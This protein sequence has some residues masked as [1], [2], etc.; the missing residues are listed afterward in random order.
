MQPYFFP[1]IGYF[2]LMNY[3]DVWVVFDDIQFIDKGWI[4]RNRIL[5]PD[6]GKEWQFITIPLKGR[7]Q[8]SNITQID[9]NDDE[10]WREKIRGQLGHYKKKVPFYF[11]TMDFVNSC[12][13]IKESNLSNY[14]SSVLI[15]TSKYLGINTN[16]TIQSQMK[17]DLGEIE[18]SGQWALKIS[19]SIGAKEYINPESG[20]SLFNK[21]E[22]ESLGI[23][24][25]FFKPEIEVYSQK[26]EKFI[27]G[28]SIIDVLMWNG[29]EVTKQMISR[30]YV[31]T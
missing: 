7:K 26:R 9:V 29:V 8:F 1:Y 6:V 18:H 3:A 4:N 22:F 25:S 2:Q 21:K 12:L 10:K 13:N 11:E 23:E 28:L 5:H 31:I 15:E 14:V 17:L 27:P 30:N 16:I 20:S 19:K 24:L